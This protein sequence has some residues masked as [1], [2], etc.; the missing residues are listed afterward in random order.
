MADPY[1]GS[2]NCVLEVLRPVHNPVGAGAPRA[3]TAVDCS[4]PANVFGRA[5]TAP[6]PCT[7]A[8]AAKTVV[9]TAYK[10]RY[11]DRAKARGLTDK[12]SRRGAAVAPARR[13]RPEQSAGAAG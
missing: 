12:A 11:Q 4:G 9:K 10:H 6:E 7:R 2:Q 8:P 13:S 3:A 5:Y 1:S